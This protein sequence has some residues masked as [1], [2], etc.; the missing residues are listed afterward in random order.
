MIFILTWTQ[1]KQCD[2]NNQFLHLT[3]RSCSYNLDQDFSDK[4]S[5]YSHVI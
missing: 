4:N 5:K 2:R 1:I 3:T